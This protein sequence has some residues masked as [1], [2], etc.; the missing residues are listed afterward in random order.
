MHDGYG[1]SLT[2]TEWHDTSP[3]V[4]G[5]EGHI[6]TR[7]RNSGKAALKRNVTLLGLLLLGLLVARLDDLT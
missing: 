5:V 6:D 4:A 3:E 7:K 2:S 1:G